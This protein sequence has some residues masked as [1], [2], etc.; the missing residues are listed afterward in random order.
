ML[1]VYTYKHNYLGGNGGT[2]FPFSKHA[3]SLFLRCIG[4]GITCGFLGLLLSGILGLVI[5]AFSILLEAHSTPEAFSSPFCSICRL[6]VVSTIDVCLFTLFIFLG[7]IGGG[8]LF[9]G[10]GATETVL[11]VDGLTFTGRLEGKCV[12]V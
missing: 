12:A 2:M 9:L 7:L 10:S 11:E 8:P 6:S 4:L 5:G 1:I 3:G